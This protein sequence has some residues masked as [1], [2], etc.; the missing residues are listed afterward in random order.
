MPHRLQS[1]LFFYVNKRSP[2]FS[3]CRVLYLPRTACSHPLIRPAGPL[4]LISALTRQIRAHSPI[5]SATAYITYM[6][7]IVRFPRKKKY[8]KA[9]LVRPGCGPTAANSGGSPPL[10]HIDAELTPVPNASELASLLASSVSLLILLIIDNLFF[11][12]YLLPFPQDQSGKNSQAKK[13]C[14]SRI[15]MPIPISTTPP[16]ISTR[17][18]QIG[19]TLPPSNMPMTVNTDAM[20][21]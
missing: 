8:Y 13:R 5:R 17:L 21:Q 6:I 2:F 14:S 7:I 4:L 11:K 12:V 15:F 3:I 9:W 16:M 20:I 1:G 10:D 19:P 18:P